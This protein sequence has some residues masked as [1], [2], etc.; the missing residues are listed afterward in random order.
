MV[1]SY[2][3]FF[4]IFDKVYDVNAISK[5]ISHLENQCLYYKLEWRLNI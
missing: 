4:C 1:D 2:R 5:L 3:N